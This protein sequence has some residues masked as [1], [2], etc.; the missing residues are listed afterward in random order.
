M[1]HILKDYIALLDRSGLLAAPIPKEIDQTAPVGMNNDHG[2][3]P[4][5]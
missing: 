5:R 4:Y 2:N 3:P 1:A